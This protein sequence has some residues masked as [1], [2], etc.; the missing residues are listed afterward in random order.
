MK[1]GE[2][3]K[4]ILLKLDEYDNTIPEMTD[5]ED[6][7]IKLPYAINEAINFAFYGKSL[8]RSWTVSQGEPFNILNETSGEHRTETIVFSASN[9]AYGYYFEIDDTA[10]ITL[11]NDDTILETINHVNNEPFRKYTAYKGIIGDGGSLKILFNG[12]YY[13][14]IRNVCIYNVLFS[15]VEKIPDYNGYYEH[16]IPKGLYKVEDVYLIDDKKTP[17]EFKTSGNKLYLPDKKGEFEIISSFFPVSVDSNTDDDFEVEMPKDV[18]YIVISKA[19][20]FLSQDGEYSEFIADSEQGMQM[21]DTN[22]GYSAPIIK[23]M[24]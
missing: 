1:Y 5:D 16:E 12:D 8:K 4:N 2:I 19:C 11:A 14:K 24:Y 18:E 22:Q 6:L 10:T 9:G 20:A 17:V 13:Y 21:L 7:V 15:N 23:R 3:K